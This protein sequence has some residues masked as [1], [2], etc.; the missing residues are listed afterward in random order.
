MIFKK[1]NYTPLTENE[2]SILDDYELEN[3]ESDAAPKEDSDTPRCGF[4]SESDVEN[5]ALK[6]LGQGKPKEDLKN[7]KK[8]TSKILSFIKK[9]RNENSTDELGLEQMGDEEYEEGGSVCHA[10]IL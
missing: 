9:L 4:I 10:R 7:P 5:E 1:S 2:E 8:F 3:A 6:G